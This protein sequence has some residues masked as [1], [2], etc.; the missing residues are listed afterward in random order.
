LGD[1]GRAR[2]PQTAKAEKILGRPSRTFAEWSADHV[3]DFT[4]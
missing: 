4:M 3:A 1:G 2:F